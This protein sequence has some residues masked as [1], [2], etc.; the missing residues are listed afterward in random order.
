[1]IIQIYN[2]LPGE[3]HYWYSKRIHKSKLVQRVL[4]F[5]VFLAFCIWESGIF[6]KVISKKQYENDIFYFILIFQL[7]TNL[8][9]LIRRG[10]DPQTR[11]SRL[12]LET[13]RRSRTEELQ[14][15]FVRERKKRWILAKRSWWTWRSETPASN[16]STLNCC[17]P[18]NNYVQNCSPQ[19]VIRQSR[20]SVNRNPQTD[21]K[22]AAWLPIC[23]QRVQ[24]FW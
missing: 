12:T 7:V 15:G 18:S 8:N 9:Y 6:L 1:M 10:G 4:R 22:V 23:D 3:I 5:V 19:H 11:S 24:N 2:I 21:F 17:Q 20:G 14:K 16:R 13:A